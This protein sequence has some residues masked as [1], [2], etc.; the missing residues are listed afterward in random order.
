MDA[1]GVIQLLHPQQL[2]SEKVRELLIA[3]ET[4]EA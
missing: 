1:S 4:V 3:T 2:L